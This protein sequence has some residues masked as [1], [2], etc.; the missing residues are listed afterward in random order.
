M[1]TSRLWPWRIRPNGRAPNRTSPAFPVRG[2]GIDNRPRPDGLLTSP[3]FPVCGGG[4]RS[5]PAGG[6]EAALP[7]GPRI[8]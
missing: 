5:S 8:P 1:P 2:D 6:A 4:I 3:A 7:A